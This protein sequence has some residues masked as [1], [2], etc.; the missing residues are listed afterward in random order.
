MTS[1]PLDPTTA[2]SPSATL[3]RCAAISHARN[4]AGLGPQSSILVAYAKQPAVDGLSMPLSLLQEHIPSITTAQALGG[5]SVPNMQ[6]QLAPA[7]FMPSML[8]QQTS[9]P[10][11]VNTNS[12]AAPPIDT[13]PNTASSYGAGTNMFGDSYGDVNMSALD[14]LFG[15]GADTELQQ[16]SH[17]VSSSMLLDVNTKHDASLGTQLTSTGL[18]DNKP[19]VE[20]SG[21]EKSGSTAGTS[22]RKI[23]SGLEDSHEEPLPWESHTD[24][25]TPAVELCEVII[26]WQTMGKLSLSRTDCVLTLIG[27]H[28]MQSTAWHM[29]N[30][31]RLVGF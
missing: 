5:M 10:L 28:D 22:P 7:T 17:D 30:W 8:P 2:V 23:L 19:I 31:Q 26:D 1:V 9:G 16:T 15:F 3:G 6:A 11:Q 24:A 12:L 29:Y 20:H 18:D 21:Q 4:I 14:E 27:S 25:I 13:R